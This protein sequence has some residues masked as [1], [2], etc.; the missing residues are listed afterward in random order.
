LAQL[1]G[2]YGDLPTR[3]RL[4]VLLLVLV[5]MVVMMVMEKWI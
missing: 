2:R 4:L 1:L 3:V 5:L